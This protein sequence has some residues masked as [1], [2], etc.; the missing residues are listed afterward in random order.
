MGTFDYLICYQGLKGKD[1]YNQ[2]STITRTSKIKSKDI[3]IIIEGLM[4]KYNYDKV[5]IYNL[6][7]LS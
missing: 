2:N 3:D 6:I 5:F 4:E 7:L 1:V